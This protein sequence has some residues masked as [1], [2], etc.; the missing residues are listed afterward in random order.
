MKKR[1]QTIFIC[2]ALVIATTFAYGP[3]KDASFIQ[4]DDNDYVVENPHIR[5]MNGSNIVWAFTTTHAANWHPLTWLSLMLDRQL[6]GLSAPGFHFTNLIFHIL[7]SLLIFLIFTAMTNAFWKSAFLAA[8]FALHPLHVE[9]V[10]WIAER[11]DV[12]SAFF[13]I[14]TIGLY[15]LYVKDKK[16]LYYIALI[17]CFALGLMAK[18]M[19][20]TLPFILLLLDYWP[21]QR[22]QRSAKP[23][24][25][26]SSPESGQTK[27]RK[28][29]AENPK[30]TAT[31]KIKEQT[32]E[33]PSWKVL[34]LEKIPL[35]ILS[36]LSCI[37]TYYAQ[38]QG[39]SV[40]SIYHLPFTDR[41]ANSL[42]SYMAYIGK[43][44]WPWNLAVYYPMPASYPLWEV[45]LAIVVLLGITY[46]VIRFHKSFPYGATGWLWYLGSLVPVIGLVQV[47]NQALADR[48]T[49]IPLIGLFLIISWGIP[50]LLKEWKYRPAFLAA[51]GAIVLITLAFT[52]LN[53]VQKWKTD[54]SLFEHTI[55]VTKDNVIANF[56]LGDARAAQGNYDAAIT[57]YNE[58]LRIDP[59]HPYTHN[60]LGIA[61][62]RRGHINEA[63]MHYQVALRFDATRPKAL[64]NLGLA[65]A[66]QG[67]YEE[68]IRYFREALL[69]KPDYLR[70]HIAL[71]DVLAK[72][73]KLQEALS[74]YEQALRMKNDLPDVHYNM[75]QILAYLGSVNEAIEH[76]YIAVRINPTFQEAHIH[77]GN[78]LLAQGRNQEAAIQFQEA[79][80]TAI[81]PDPIP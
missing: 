62:Q 19:L 13:G 61:L 59:N 29:G 79:S 18:P 8:L 80:K 65:A 55:N 23:G 36:T 20:V 22:F 69:L 28:Q 60:N 3:I 58:V 47:G 52:T 74:S 30:K 71:G 81:L 51:G 73:G 38:Q 39:G 21:L 27:K 33:P 50:D 77:L 44:F 43:M 16:P 40:I 35:F 45:S 25:I 14:C 7:N 34:I 57:S 6:Y 42:I 49:Y 53:Q 32:V 56:C 78:L 12:L 64:T 48:Y 24:K 76:L 1:Y 15:A 54:I 66:T 72:T 17:G 2:I 11:K 41:I 9:S 68:A 70:P 10:A 75:A 67:N 5:E 31:Q 4:L 63:I 46:L 26:S 37:M